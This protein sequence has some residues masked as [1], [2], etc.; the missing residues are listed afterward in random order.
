MDL[1]YYRERAKVELIKLV[2]NNIGRLFTPLE[3]LLMTLE[4][5]KLLPSTWKAFEPFGGYGLWTV[6]DYID[7]VQSLDIV[8]LDDRIYKGLVKTY[9]NNPRVNTYHCDCMKFMSETTN[10]YNFVIVDCPLN[11]S[12]KSFLPPL[13]KLLEPGAVML[14]TL[15]LSTFVHFDDVSVGLTRLS[16][17]PPALIFPWAR[18]VDAGF[19]AVIMPQDC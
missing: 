17:V 18:N 10:S 2:K 14:L 1:R 3:T 12:Y 6:P 15:P 8:E 9:K 7:R 11:M 16:P 5:Q 4:S 19:A 13:F